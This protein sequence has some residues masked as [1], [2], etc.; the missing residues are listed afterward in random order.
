[1]EKIE[2]RL[3]EIIVIK[4]GKYISMTAINMHS[5]VFDNIKQ[6]Q[7][8]Q[9]KEGEVVFKIVKKDTY[10][11][12][13]TSYI[14]KNLYDRIGGSVKV[15]IEFVDKIPRTSGGKYRFLIQKLPINFGGVEK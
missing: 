2:G 4:T 12:E 7:F 3:Q 11:E 9:D 5:N 10:T 13:D 8:Y 1:M 15:Y 14:L 6:F